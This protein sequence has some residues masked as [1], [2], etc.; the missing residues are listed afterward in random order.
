MGIPGGLFGDGREGGALFFGFNDADGLAVHQQKI[1]A[2]PGFERNLSNGDAASGGEVEGL[3]ILHEPACG[4]EF[5]V[6]LL[7]RALF[8]EELR[9]ET[10]RPPRRLLAGKSGALRNDKNATSA[11][12]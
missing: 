5:R 9:H 11:F 6:N 12:R 7:P 1:V 2:G 8:W 10:N 3:V 4:D